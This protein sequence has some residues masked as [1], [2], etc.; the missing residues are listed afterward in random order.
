MSCLS[1]CLFPSHYVVEYLVRME[2]GNFFGL[3][4]EGRCSELE[5]AHVIAIRT[6]KRCTP[7]CSFSW[8]AFLFMK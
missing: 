2:Q 5:L 3:M 1:V 8:L 6:T 7:F 4:V